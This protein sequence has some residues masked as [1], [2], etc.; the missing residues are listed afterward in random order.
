MYLFLTL[1]LSLSLR[2]PSRMRI[3]ISLRYLMLF[4]VHI[5]LMFVPIY[6]FTYIDTWF[7][8]LY[9]RTTNPDRIS[10]QRIGLTMS[11]GYVLFDGADPN[12]IVVPCMLGAL[13]SH[14]RRLDAQHPLDA[15]VV[16]DE[17][18]LRRVDVQLLAGA[19]QLMARGAL[20][21][22]VHFQFAQQ[23]ALL[24]AGRRTGRVNLL[25]KKNTIISLQIMHPFVHRVLPA[26]SEFPSISPSECRTDRS[27]WPT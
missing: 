1:C 27:A 17:H 9:G 26:S 8:I 5:V 15:V 13:Q 16:L 10:N 20:Q 4:L 23:F 11:I 18:H 25:T 2:L 6:I 22:L 3:R 21:K 14:E 24:F 12:S 7:V 19:Q